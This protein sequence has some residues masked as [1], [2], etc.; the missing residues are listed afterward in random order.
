ML[1]AIASSTAAVSRTER[2]TTPSVAS[3]AQ[4]SPKSGPAETRPRDGLSP[5]R[6][7]SLAGIRIEPPPSLA[8]PTA[9]IRAATAAADP[10][11]EPPVERVTS[12]GL[13]LGPKA[14]GSVVALS[15]N[16]GVL[17]LPTLIKPAALN[18]AAR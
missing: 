13:R 9:T 8:C 17:V 11:L 5:T 7:H 10:P 1:P 3:P 14:S 4:K 16:S 12:Q 18:F 2:L 15:P 6:P